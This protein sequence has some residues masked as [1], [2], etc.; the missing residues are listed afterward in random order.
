MIHAFILDVA[1]ASRILICNFCYILIENTT[2]GDILERSGLLIGVDTERS[3]I[4]FD[5][6]Q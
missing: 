5:V 1:S 2:D 4:F 6:V 3:A